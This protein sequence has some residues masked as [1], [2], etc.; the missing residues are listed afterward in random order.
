MFIVA[1][2]SLSHRQNIV[3]VASLSHRQ[4]IVAVASLSHRQNIVAVASLSHRQI[5]TGRGVLRLSSTILAGVRHQ[6]KEV[7]SIFAAKDEPPL[8]KV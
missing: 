8:Q 1:V 2:A 7:K 6:P 3:A 4:N 5:A